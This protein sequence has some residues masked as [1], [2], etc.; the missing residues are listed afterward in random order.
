MR[1]P[2]LC[3][4]SAG[5]PITIEVERERAGRS[6]Q[7]GVAHRHSRRHS[8]QDRDAAEE[9]EPV[10]VAGLGLCYPVGNHIVAVRPNSPASEA[11]L[12]S[13]DVINSLAIP[14]IKSESPK[15]GW[16]AW[17][18]S[19]VWNRADAPRSLSSAKNHPTGLRPS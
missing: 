9:N 12:K 6:A 15:R 10:D 7:G 1:L 16:F 3:L 13:G 19:L 18:V 8:S 2:S 11:G 5:K 4:E 17:L 14:P